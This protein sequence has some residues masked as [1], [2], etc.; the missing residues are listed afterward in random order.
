MLYNRYRNDSLPPAGG[1]SFLDKRTVGGITTKNVT[2]VGVKLEARKRSTYDTVTPKF[3][4]RISQGE[5][6]NN[7]FLS[8]VNTYDCGGTYIFDAR[9]SPPDPTQHNS[10][11]YYAQ[12]GHE[13]NNRYKNYAYG[14]VTLPIASDLQKAQ[15]DALAAV[16]KTDFDVGT[17]L[18]EWS[19][20][21]MLHRDVCNALLKVFTEF[22]SVKVKRSRFSK[23]V[24]YDL[25]GNP[26]LNRKGKPVYRY[27]HDPQEVY[28]RG[29]FA[30]AKDVSNLY[31][32]GRY[33]IGPL[34]GDLENAWKYMGRKYNPRNTARAEVFSSGSVVVTNKRNLDKGYFDEIVTTTRIFKTR[35]GILYDSDAASRALAGLGLTRPLSMAWELVPYSF[36]AD[37]LL[38]VGTWLDAMQPAGFN[39]NLC[40][41]VST[42]EVLA[43]TIVLGPFVRTKVDAQYETTSTFSNEWLSRTQT[44]KSRLAWEPTLPKYPAL[45]SGFNSIRS[46]DLASLVMQKMRIRI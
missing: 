17:F 33:G 5:I 6:I 44:T 37:W 38:D 41:W 3:K 23:V 28:G 18:A 21:K 11:Y 24:D 22:E 36:V 4:E 35:V 8:V 19:K 46:F 30:K 14:S 29:K 34:L 40:A 39:R 10:Y 25:K 15:I 1:T 2:Y 12:N 32:T 9:Y 20:T 13:I 7:D 43:Q 16:N 26:K 27:L 45:G 31:L 42:V